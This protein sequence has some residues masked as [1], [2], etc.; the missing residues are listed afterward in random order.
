MTSTFDSY[1][2]EFK[3]NLSGALEQIQVIKD[4]FGDKRK[5]AKDAS[6]K[7]LDNAK[8]SLD[9]MNL[10]VREAK[11]R[12]PN[13]YPQLQSRLAKAKVDLDRCKKDQREALA[14]TPDLGAQ[15]AELFGNRGAHDFEDERDTASL[16][17]REEQNLQTLRKAGQTLAEA[18]TMGRDIIGNLDDQSSVLRRVA[19]R[20][21]DIRASITRGDRRIRS[22]MSRAI[23]NRYLLWIIMGIL[24]VVIVI[25]VIAKFS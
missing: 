19:N 24:L 10:E 21:A 9:Q 4:S 16:I 11:D 15:K 12:Y 7:A 2:Q 13:T 1:E 14:A 17:Q 3:Q 5:L 8:Q 23:V 25:L 6:E 22:M 20:V 18:E